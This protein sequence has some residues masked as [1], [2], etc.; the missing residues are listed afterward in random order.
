[1]GTV[2]GTDEDSYLKYSII[3]IC[4]YIYVAPPRG[5]QN[6]NFTDGTWTAELRELAEPY[7]LMMLRRLHYLGRNAKRPHDQITALILSLDIAVGR[8]GPRK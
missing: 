1:M 2:L 8:V 4:Y 6:G 3:S 5:V 7:L